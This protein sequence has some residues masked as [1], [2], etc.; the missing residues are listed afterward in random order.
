MIVLNHFY[1]SLFIFMGYLSIK[2]FLHSLLE[3]IF[4]CSISLCEWLFEIVIYA[5]KNC[6]CKVKRGK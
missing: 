5:K 6:T 4:S 2:S 3:L 1:F